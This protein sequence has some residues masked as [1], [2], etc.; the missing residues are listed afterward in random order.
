MKRTVLRIFAILS[1]AG[2]L[3]LMVDAFIPNPARVESA[4]VERGELIVSIS[5]EGQARIREKYTVYSPSD[6]LIARVTLRPGDAVRRGDVLARLM[7]LEPALLDA[8][9]R[10]IAEGRARAAEDASAQAQAAVDRAEEAQK[11]IVAELERA[12]SLT[13]QG[14]ATRRDLE[15]AETELRVSQSE[16]KALALGASV[17]AHEA[18]AAKAALDWP[19]TSRST[20]SMSLTSPIDGL[21]L[22]V[23]RESEGAVAAGAPILEVGAPGD[24]EV[25]VSVLTR[26]AHRI[27]K[28]MLALVGGFGG[29]ELRGK[30]RRIDPS[31][32]PKISPLGLE[33][34]RVNVIVDLVDS[35]P[36]TIGDGFAVEVR[37]VVADLKD[38]LKVPSSALFRVADLWSAYVIVDG[39]AKLVE[40]KVG[41]TDSLE[42]EVLGGLSPGDVVIVHPGESLSEGVRVRGAGA[43]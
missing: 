14:A 40:V 26:D 19:M 37:F 24:L 31:A 1:V 22:R 6:G 8:R 35:S 3:A 17:A 38:V 41:A 16:L 18:Q 29:E 25:V 21:V 23:V 4:V 39:K 10:A 28:G 36:S 5:E 30:V 13:G 11:L 20:K 43:D 9:S 2:L 12:R 27:T 15:R 33:E 32:F 42:F 7:P 34:Q